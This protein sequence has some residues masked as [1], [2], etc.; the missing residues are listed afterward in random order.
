MFAD[1][2][3]L[4]LSHKNLKTLFS[5]VNKELKNIHEWLK[6]NKLSLNAKK[7]HYSLFHPAQKSDDLRLILPIV[8]INDTTIERKPV[9]KF[10]EV[11]SDENLSWTLHINVIKNKI[12]KNLGLLYKARH[13][14][15][16][17]G[18]K[19][20]YF[21]YVHCYPTYANIAWGSTHNSKLINISL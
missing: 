21:S 16:S 1:Y 7:K 19:Q 5:T 8:K 11:L 4:F 2:T 17:Y 10:L 12:S 3:N 15:N 6:S 13:L 20:L 9:I 14:I 18:L